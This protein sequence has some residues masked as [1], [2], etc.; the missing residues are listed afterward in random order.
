MISFIKFLVLSENKM[1]FLATQSGIPLPHIEKLATADPTPKKKYLPW[2]VNQVKRNKIRGD[3]LD[4]YHPDTLKVHHDALSK[5][6]AAKGQL[7]DINKYAHIGKIRRALRVADDNK[8]NKAHEEKFGQ[9]VLNKG[10]HHVY[11]VT[12]PEQATAHGAGTQWCTRIKNGG[13]QTQYL[14]QGTLHVHYPP[15][16]IKPGKPGFDKDTHDKFQSFT[17]HEM[18]SELG[19]EFRDRADHTVSR[20]AH[21]K[22]HPVLKDA[23]HWQKFKEAQRNHTGPEDNEDNDEHDHDYEQEQIHELAHSRNSDDRI[24]AVIDHDAHNNDHPHLYDDHDSEV[25]TAII[26]HETEKGYNQRDRV[27]ARYKDDN[28]HDVLGHVAEHA[29]H[30]GIIKHMVDNHFDVEQVKYGLAAN[31]LTPTP[32]KHKLAEVQDELTNHGNKYLHS[33]LA[34]NPRSSWKEEAHPGYD[35]SLHHKLLDHPHGLTAHGYDA[36]ATSVSDSSK[37][38]KTLIDK[39]ANKK[40][41]EEAHM[42]VAKHFGHE[43]K[44]FNKLK[45]SMFGT[46]HKHLAKHRPEEYTKPESHFAGKLDAAGTGNEAAHDALI[47]NH[48]P[49]GEVP[50]RDE[51]SAAIVRTGKLRHVEHFKD[52]ESPDTVSAIRSRIPGMHSEHNGGDEGRKTLAVLAT[53]KNP[54]I[55][56]QVAH[57]ATIHRGTVHLVNKLIHDPV[58]TVRYAAIQNSDLSPELRKHVHENDPN[59]EIRRIAG[60]YRENKGEI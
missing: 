45:N 49:E 27:H 24:R 31:P 41:N 37:G 53:S 55:R 6:D 29:G 60:V 7:G 33:E 51:I 12:E 35:S 4:T 38:D 25:K 15:K 44:Y 57:H 36:I 54:K 59:P 50:L 39:M 1:Q 21:E 26:D 8:Q 18:D 2:L 17:P 22:A 16:A 19:P 11:E 10:G 42:A 52:T 32:V 23:P 3:M 5:F 43:D 48:P 20:E 40:D 14:S 34:K 28:D 46:V 9:R 58:D 30:P 56:S 13:Y 47:K